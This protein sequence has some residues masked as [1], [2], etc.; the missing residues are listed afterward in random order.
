MKYVI[1]R[2]GRKK[3]FDKSKIEN[4]ILKAFSAVD[5]EI[6]DYAKEKAKNIADYIEG[7]E[8]DHTLGVEE[9]QDLVENGLMSCK[10]KDVAKAY[11][12]YR[13]ERSK[14]RQMKTSLMETL[15]ILSTKML[16]LMNILLAADAVRQ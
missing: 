7:Y 3:E 5:G 16:T 10:R 8:A 6:T 13:E 4:A 9:V 1:K 2:D 14:V 11:I 15:L 12:L